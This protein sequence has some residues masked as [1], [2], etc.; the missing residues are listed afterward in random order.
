MNDIYDKTTCGNLDCKVTTNLKSCLNCKIIKYCSKECQK[1]HWTEHKHIC[2]IIMLT[3]AKI[4]PLIE[5][6]NIMMLN[7]QL[8]IKSVP[9]TV[10][11]NTINSITYDERLN[12]ALM[13]KYENATYN[14]IDS[15][16]KEE[17]RNINLSLI[18]DI[19]CD[20]QRLVMIKLSDKVIVTTRCDCVEHQ[21]NINY[22]YF[23]YKA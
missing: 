5:E 18:E 9:K 10:L 19:E 12:K 3:S 22:F 2:K 11:R 17:W 23:V 13:F 8:L 4:R 14:F 7:T 16:N 1:T 21:D 6:Y 15:D 20:R